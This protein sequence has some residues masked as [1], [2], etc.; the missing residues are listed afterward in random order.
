MGIW[1]CVPIDRFWNPT[2]G[3]DQGFC[4]IEDKKFFFG[5]ILVH[6]IL[7]VCIIALPVL[8]VLKLQLPRAQ[9]IGIS[10][11]FVFGIV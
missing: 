7:D 1:H 8:Q 3:G 2:A 10:L 5:T 6:V 9:K 4:A 11:M